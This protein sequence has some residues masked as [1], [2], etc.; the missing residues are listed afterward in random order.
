MWKRAG[1]SPPRQ[2]RSSAGCRANPVRSSAA[3]PH[4]SSPHSR[5]VRDASVTEGNA[6]STNAVFSVSLSASSPQTITLAYA[7]SN[8]TATAGSDY[9]S[10][11]G[12]LTIAAGQTSGTIAVP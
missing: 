11:S 2:A 8:G 10:T 7:T 5:L 6:G 4:R 9:A 1:G 12:T 3:A